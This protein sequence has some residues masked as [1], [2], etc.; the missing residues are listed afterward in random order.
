MIAD[1]SQLFDQSSLS[2][3]CFL[4]FLRHFTARQ[5]S[6]LCRALY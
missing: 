4:T 6:L 5:H 2:F 3:E 1:L